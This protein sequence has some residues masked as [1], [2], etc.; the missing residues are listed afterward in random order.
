MFRPDEVKPCV[1][2]YAQQARSPSGTGSPVEV[3]IRTYGY[4]P[5]IAAS[6][7]IAIG[8]LRVDDLALRPHRP[9][10]PRPLGQRRPP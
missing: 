7:H 1:T 8:D 5:R 4:S 2:Q 9:R 3:S 6:R 10:A